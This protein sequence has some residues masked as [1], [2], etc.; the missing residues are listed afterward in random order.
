MG[1]AYVTPVAPALRSVFSP[2][3]PPQIVHVGITDWRM[4]PQAREQYGGVP[5]RAALKREQKAISSL[6]G[7]WQGE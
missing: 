6:E 4:V 2:C 5:F 1:G 3:D 7:V